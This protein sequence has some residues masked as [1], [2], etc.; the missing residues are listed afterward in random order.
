MDLK[1]VETLAR[2]LMT[3]HG[4]TSWNWSLRLVHSRTFAGR[5]YTHCWH[6]VPEFSRG[7]I[8]LSIEF[9]EAFDEENVRDTILHEIAHAL[10]ESEWGTY[11]TGPKKG[12]KYRIAHGES[13]K[14]VARRIGC[15][16]ERCV[17]LEAPRPKSKYHLV[18]PNGHEVGRSRMTFQGKYMSCVR[19]DSTYSPRFRF[20]WY[21]G[22]TLVH[23]NWGG[24][25][26]FTVSMSLSALSPE[27]MSIMT[28][29]PLSEPPKARREPVTAS[30]VVE[31]DQGQ[32]FI[33]W[34]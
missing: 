1:E 3:H 14:A 15:S 17:P 11:K 23:R 18:C 4:L 34:D 25:E 21:E 16:G 13:W 19:C 20:N 12:R 6:K 31:Y 30:R 26:K 2:Q 10:T 28:G 29:S 8:E 27:V 22:S 5:C 7:K 24:E 33:N 32:S 9:M